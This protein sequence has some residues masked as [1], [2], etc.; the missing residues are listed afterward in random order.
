MAGAE[1]QPSGDVKTAPATAA[2]LTLRTRTGQSNASLQ[3]GN[4]ANRWCPGQGNTEGI[5]RPPSWRVSFLER[6]VV[7]DTSVDGTFPIGRCAISA[8]V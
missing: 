4:Y 8:P 3:P 2:G 5:V 7:A 6:F 1:G